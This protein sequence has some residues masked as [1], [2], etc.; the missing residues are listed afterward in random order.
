[1]A[2]HLKLDYDDEH[3]LPIL[4]CHNCNA[5]Q[6]IFSEEYNQ[7]ARCGCCGARVSNNAY[8]FTKYRDYR[9]LYHIEGN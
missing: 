3:K 9:F 1:M 4:I 5:Q 6:F 7:Q 8:E 2:T